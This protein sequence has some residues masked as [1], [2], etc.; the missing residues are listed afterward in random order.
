MIAP[1]VLACEVPGCGV[2]AF[3]AKDFQRGDIVLQ[4]QAIFISAVDTPSRRNEEIYKALLAELHS[5]RLTADFTPNAHLG[6][7][8]ALRD[9]GVQG[10]KDFL[11]KKCHGDPEQLPNPR[12]ARQEAAPLRRCIASGILPPACAALAAV[13]YAKLRMAIQLNGFRFNFNAQ[14]GDFGY[15]TGEV[16]FDKISRLNHSCTP[17][18]DFNL[19]WDADNETVVNTITASTPIRTNEE[20]N[21]SYLPLRL[22]LP[23]EERRAQ[24][25]KHWGFHCRC[26]RCLL[27]GGAPCVATPAVSRIPHRSDT[28]SEGSDSEGICWEDLC[29]PDA[30]DTK[31]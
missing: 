31:C 18:L 4:E 21:I 28:R 19:S 29:D 9:L 2:A 12:L 27:E 13:E 16:L 24:L 14:E 30:T 6:A 26:S 10:C 17:N 7:L 23:V 8:V 3:A 15:D 25:L 20:L 22:K 1:G 5:R 11:L